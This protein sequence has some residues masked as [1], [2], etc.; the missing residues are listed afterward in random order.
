M[1]VEA[2]VLL[3]PSLHFRV[4][5]RGVIVHDQM[6]LKMFGRFAIDFFEKLQPLLVPVL[7]LDAADQ[8]SLKI[9]QRSKQ[10]DSAVADIVMR[11]RT[12]MPDPQRQTR[13]RTLQGLNLAFLIAAEH[14]SLVW[15]VEIQ[16]DNI[17]KLLFEMWIIGQ[18]EGTGQVRFQ[19]IGGPESVHAGGRDPGDSRHAPTAPSRLADSRLSDLFKDTTYGVSRQGRFAP[20]PWL[21]EQTVQSQRLKTL[22]P[23]GDRGE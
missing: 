15:R 13:L 20:T 18:F 17:P 16:P 14:Q 10:G 3:K 8:A 23:T 7:A 6:Q 5:V 22:A 9:I 4:F 12:D 21:V 11:L 2:F 1:H 19:V